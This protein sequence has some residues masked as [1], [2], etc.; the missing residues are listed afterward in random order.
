MDAK[1][2]NIAEDFEQNAQNN[3]SEAE[4]SIINTTYS[5]NETVDSYTNF[6]THESSSETLHNND[7]SSH[8]TVSY[9]TEISECYTDNI[10]TETVDCEDTK[11]IIENE[12]SEEPKIN[13]DVNISMETS[14]DADNVNENVENDYVTEYKVGETQTEY[15]TNENDLPESKIIIEEPIENSE[16]NAQNVEELMD[17]K[18]EEGLTTEVTIEEIEH[19]PLPDYGEAMDT[20]ESD[21]VVTE[22]DSS[23]H[24]ES[25]RTEKSITEDNKAETSSEV[26]ED[27]ERSD[28][29][30]KES[31]FHLVKEPSNVSE[32]MYT[33]NINIY[34]TKNQIFYIFT[35]VLL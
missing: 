18:I 34:V 35:V 1:S 20:Q 33:L 14:Q 6:E 5:Q 24:F 17:H 11:D 32:G 15:A 13:E 29:N 9:D 2:I 16:E 21:N 7:L 23:M 3:G 10:C 12:G 31:S 4:V 8:N 25:V 28:E 26:I 22:V 30:I 27:A 19:A